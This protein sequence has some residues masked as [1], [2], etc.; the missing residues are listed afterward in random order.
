MGGIKQW[1]IKEGTTIIKGKA[2][3]QLSEG[4][5]YVGG[6]EQIFVLEPWKYGSLF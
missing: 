4:T 5:Q 2:A 6:A 1:L 3:P